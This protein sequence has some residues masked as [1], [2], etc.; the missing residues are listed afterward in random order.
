MEHRNHQ[1]QKQQETSADPYHIHYETNLDT[2]A[3]TECTGLMPYGTETSMEWDSFREIFDFF[4]QAHP[5]EQD[6]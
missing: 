5:R 2:N 1:D 3:C 4:P 6:L